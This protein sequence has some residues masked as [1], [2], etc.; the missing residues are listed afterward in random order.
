MTVK[1]KSPVILA[2]LALVAALRVVFATSCL[3][4]LAD[5]SPIGAM[6]LFG[7][8]CFT[9]ASWRRGSNGLHDVS[10]RRAGGWLAAFGWPLLTLWIS[11]VFLN[12]FEFYGHWRLFYSGFYWVYGAFALMVVVGRLLLTRVTVTR[13]LLA[14]VAAVLIHWFVTDFGTWLEGTMYP[15]TFAGYIECLVAAIPY[16]R[17]QLTGNVIYSAILFGA[18]AWMTRRASPAGRI[19]SGAPVPVQP[20]RP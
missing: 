18:V 6:A 3:S 8:A 16:E 19:T 10:G 7:G 13:V 15:K 17:Y 14:S 4:P 20:A 1:P 9:A 12:R 5:F 11:D 2:M